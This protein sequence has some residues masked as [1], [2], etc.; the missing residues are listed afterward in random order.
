[1]SRWLHDTA[2]RFE[3]ETGVAV[4]LELMATDDVISRFTVAAEAGNPP[5]VQYLWNG[6]YHMESVWKGYL[7]ALNGLLPRELL[8]RCGATELSVFEGQNYRVGFYASGFGLAYNKALF[9]RAGL[10][11]DAPPQTWTGFLDACDRL[12]VSGT[13]PIGGGVKDGYFGDWYFTNA[14]TQNLDSPADAISLFIGHLDW[15]EP[16]YHEHWTRLHELHKLAFLN[17]DITELDHFEGTRL[18]DDGRVAMCLDVTPSLSAAEAKLGRGN[19][20]FTVLPVFGRGRLAG[21]PITYAH[22]FGIPRGAADR[23]NAIR[24]LEFMHSK[25]RLQAMWSIAKQI[26]ADEGFDAAVI[27]DPLI[28]NVYARWFAGPHTP[29]IGDLMPTRFWTDVMF[30]ASQRILAGEMTGEQAGDLAYAVT[31][32]WRRDNPQAVSHYARWRRDLAL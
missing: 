22:G 28:D 19:V 15:R 17:D 16:Q 30:V 32:E 18:F 13:I 29:F 21:V 6:I 25:E 1:M 31:E 7:E 23:A 12:K 2:S 24:L 11:A 4:H 8:R 27:D 14:L 5:D 20:G 9:E 3:L 10:S 26:P